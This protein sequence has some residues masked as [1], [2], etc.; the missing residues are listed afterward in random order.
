MG[1]ELFFEEAKI[2]MKLVEEVLR[3]VGVGEM[4][5]EERREIEERVRKA[6]KKLRE[7]DKS[8]LLV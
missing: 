3:E 6:V 4:D 8:R 7:R 5:E 1:R 2:L